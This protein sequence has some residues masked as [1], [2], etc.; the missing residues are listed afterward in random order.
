[1]QQV[2]RKTK[3][4]TPSRRPAKNDNEGPKVIVWP[5]E[6]EDTVATERLSSSERM[7]SKPIENPGWL[8]DIF[9]P[10]HNYLSVEN[11]NDKKESYPPKWALKFFGNVMLGLVPV[12]LIL[13]ATTYYY[14]VVAIGAWVSVGLILATGLYSG[15]V[16]YPNTR[17]STEIDVPNSFVAVLTAG[18]TRVRKV[19]Q[20]GK[21]DFPTLWLP[22]KFRGRKYQ[23]SAVLVNMIKSTWDG[24]VK[25]MTKQK[26]LMLVNFAVGQRTK[27]D[28]E[29]ILLSSQYTDAQAEKLIMDEAAT[30][31]GITTKM[32]SVVDYVTKVVEQEED[33]DGVTE[34]S[35]G[36]DWLNYVLR[37]V[38]ASLNTTDVVFIRNNEGVLELYHKKMGK[39]LEPYFKDHDWLSDV[40][41]EAIERG[42]QAEALENAMRT[43]MRVIEE[44]AEKLRTE[45]AIKFIKEEDLT[46]TQKE[47]LKKLARGEEG[48][49]SIDELGIF[50]PIAAQDAIRTC[51][52]MMD[53]FE[54][55][56]INDPFGMSSPDAIAKAVESVVEKGIQAWVK[57]KNK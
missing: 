15:F 21:F 41:R 43:K 29:S 26:S 9:D 23:F 6:P 31:V 51:M 42:T 49:K 45:I 8:N 13:L 17:K 14:G 38:L 18:G 30:A 40:T 56:S 2:R 3:R 36:L 55:E 20:E 54:N 34:Q 16:V 25:A 39:Y 10:E 4:P 27:S 7:V 48:A 35:I 52:I 50:A 47:G 53:E 12:L 22:F 46:A 11:V 5:H 33:V 44:S 19:L 28:L 57:S 37:Q 32:G 1:M 24:V